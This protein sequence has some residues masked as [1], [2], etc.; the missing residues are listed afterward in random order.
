[1]EYID[2]FIKRKEHVPNWEELS[3]Q[4]QD[5]LLHHWKKDIERH[6]DY[7]EI[8]KGVLNEKQNIQ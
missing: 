7:M 5:N 4:H 8:K 3:K 6:K 2:D 1:M